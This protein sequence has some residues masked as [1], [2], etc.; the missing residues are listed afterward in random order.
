MPFH[1][2]SSTSTSASPRTSP[3]TSGPS[4]SRCCASCVAH[5]DRTAMLVRWWLEVADRR[6]SCHPHPS[7]QDCDVTG[8][9]EVLIPSLP[10]TRFRDL[11]G[12]T[13]YEE[14]E[15]A[16]ARARTILD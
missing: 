9:Q 16:G 7:G 5:C 8:L 11:I 13:R 14:L 6:R 12:D 2:T 4:S 3:R 1:A 10:L 15:A